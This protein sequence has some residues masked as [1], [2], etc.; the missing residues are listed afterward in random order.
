MEPGKI[1]SG[2]L[3]AIN[4]TIS[5]TDYGHGQ[6][7]TLPVAFYDNDLVTLFVEPYEGGIRV[8]DQ[9][10]TA[11]RLHMANVDLDNKKIAEAWRRSVASLGAQSMAAE[12]GVVTAWGSETEVGNLLIAVAEAAMRVDQL[13]WTVTERRPMRFR[14]RVAH[15]LSEV[16]GGPEYVTPNAHIQLT[17]GRAKR[18]TAS[19]SVDP[20]RP[21]YVQAISE[22]SGDQGT[23]H[24]YF[25]F[26]HTDIER[27][28]KLA[29][30]SGTPDT[31]PHLEAELRGV[32]DVAYFDSRNDLETKLSQRLI[33]SP[34]A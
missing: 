7:V 14:D 4:D 1:R 9:G 12:E 23:E 22:N 24:C 28:R 17:S 11:M 8:S 21:I 10:T 19:I 27:D 26:S 25:I 5:V 31:W 16:A 3:S 13:R 15:R 20:K 18:V 32:A 34:W 29:V 33:S 30:A 2:V 6:L